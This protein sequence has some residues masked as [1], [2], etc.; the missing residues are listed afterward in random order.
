MKTPTDQPA[1]QQIGITGL[2]RAQS[3]TETKTKTKKVEIEIAH[4]TSA[5]QKTSSRSSDAPFAE[6]IK[7]AALIKT[8]ATHLR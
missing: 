3:K 8:A 7:I 6:E 5:K 4:S 1:S 2:K